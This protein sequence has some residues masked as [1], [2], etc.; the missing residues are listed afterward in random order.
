MKYYVEV[1]QAQ[2]E[3]QSAN[4]ATSA[5]ADVVLR[6]NSF[7]FETLQKLRCGLKSLKFVALLLRCAFK[8]FSINS[9]LLY[10][11]FNFVSFRL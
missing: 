11:E 5:I 2:L 3:T 8:F 1:G 9:T 10:I 6:F 4:S 7:F